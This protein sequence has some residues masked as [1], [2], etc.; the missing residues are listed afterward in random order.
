MPP[1]LVSSESPLALPGMTLGPP[2][3]ALLSS[4]M[5][6]FMGKGE[7]EDQGGQA[8]PSPPLFRTLD[9]HDYSLQPREASPSSSKS[10]VLQELLQTRPGQGDVQIISSAPVGPQRAAPQSAGTGRWWHE[11][12]WCRESNA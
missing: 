9:S 12:P 1:A 6:H 4:D 10:F 8:K 5:F 11:L 2:Q 3:W 7:E